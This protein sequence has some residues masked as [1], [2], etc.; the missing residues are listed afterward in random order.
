VIE[1]IHGLNLIANA[2][3]RDGQIG[4]IA[5]TQKV[6]KYSS[7]YSLKQCRSLSHQ[8][9]LGLV[10]NLIGFE[11]LLDLSNEGSNHRSCIASQ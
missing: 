2:V 9:H 6:H 3:G 5:G 8:L 4:I 11:V 1:R 10:H 7:G